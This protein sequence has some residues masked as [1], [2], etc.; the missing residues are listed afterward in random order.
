M[1]G[2]T[3]PVI[4][5]R[6]RYRAMLAKTVGLMEA[7]GYAPDVVIMLSRG[8]FIVGAELAIRLS[9][10]RVIGQS[11]IKENGTRRLDSTAHWGD[12]GGART[13]IVDDSSIT[14]RLFR[15]TRDE[16]VS[17]GGIPATCT[18]IVVGE[19]EA[20]YFAEHFNDMPLY[21]WEA[22]RS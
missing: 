18:P 4:I 16:V 17:R 19:A 11:V 9:V 8:G 13:L 12:I 5:G 3:R 20:T 21:Y 15:L 22:N 10:E 6:L 14:G 1:Q 7:D 2:N